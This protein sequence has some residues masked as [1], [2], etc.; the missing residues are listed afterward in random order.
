VKIRFETTI[1]DLVAFNRYHFANSPIW[2]KQIWL[3]SLLLPGIVGLVLLVY[4]A[5]NTR[6]GFDGGPGNDPTLGLEFSTFGVFL[7][8]SVAW[9]LFLRWRMSAALDSNT[10]KLLAEGT[11]RAIFGWHDLELVGNRLVMN[12]ELIHSSID[13]RAIEK[14]VGNEQYTFIY[15]ASAEAYI[16]PMQLFPEDEYSAFVAEL[17]QAWDKRHAPPLEKANEPSLCPPDVRIIER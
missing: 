15:I 10:R 3:R 17:R 11:N 2:R 4:Y 9:V 16:I 8:F 7:F 14:I 5:T 6:R 12:S 13:L 1:E